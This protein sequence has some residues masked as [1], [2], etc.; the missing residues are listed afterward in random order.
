MTNESTN[1]DYSG[2][3]TLTG[4]AKAPVELSNKHNLEN[5]YIKPNSVDGDLAI[6]N[7]EYV[8]TNQETGGST[9]MGTVST[10]ISGDLD[11]GYV[12]NVNG[13]LVIDGADDV[14]IAHNAVSGTIQSVGE[15]QQFRDESDTKP[16]SLSVF[17]RDVTG[18]Q[19]QE[20]VNSPTTGVSVNGCENNV[21]IKDVTDNIHVYVLGWN[22]NVRINAKRATVTLHMTGSHNTIE[23]NP[24]TD[25]EIATNSGIEN[26]IEQ[27]TFPVTD[28]IESSKS[29]AYNDAFF[30]RRKITYQEPAMDKDICPG[31]GAKAD[32]VIERH[33]EDAFFILS[34]P[35]YH[36]ETGDVSYECE[37]CSG[38][39]MPKVELTEAERKDIL[40]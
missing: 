30:G 6:K 36:F 28:L 40:Q 3:I 24:Y 7:V 13:G 5:V 29:E 22:N 37:E 15:E 20:T 26:A 17:D 23:V 35:L 1:T 16:P 33:Q 34:Y 19:Q 18:W 10:E 11:D 32:A 8:F 38:N 21:T 14:F 31:C 12:E 25:L 9:N 39:A 2:D 4:D 27:D